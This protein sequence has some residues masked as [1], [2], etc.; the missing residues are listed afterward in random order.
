MKIIDNLYTNEFMSELIEKSN[1]KNSMI[2]KIKNYCYQHID[3][4]DGIIIPGGLDVEYSV[5]TRIPQK[6]SSYKDFRRTL[7]DL[8]TV[9]RCVTK[10]IPLLG[11][12]RGCQVINVYYGGT[13]DQVSNKQNA[14]IK[15]ENRL[16][17]NVENREKTRF[18][19]FDKNSIHFGISLHNQY[20]NKLGRGLIN[21]SIAKNNKF[22]VKSVETQVGSIVLGV[23]FHPEFY[24]EPEYMQISSDQNNSNK[25][26][27]RAIFDYFFKTFFTYK[28]KKNLLGHFYCKK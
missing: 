23:Q 3:I 6:C 20:I 8:F 28:T 25:E 26:M 27:N 11:I 10:G 18:K 4:C 12:C 13:L 19:I 2:E 1:T 17:C 21:T 14:N 9:H 16:L 22:I 5:Y 7:I 24:N 15:N